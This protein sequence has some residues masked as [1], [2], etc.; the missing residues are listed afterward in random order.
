MRHVAADEGHVLHARYADVGNERGVAE[1][2]PGILS[3]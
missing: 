3:A 2:M 1:K